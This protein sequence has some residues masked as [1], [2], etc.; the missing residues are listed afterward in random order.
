M[1]RHLV[2][3]LCDDG[4]LQQ[5]ALEPKDSFCSPEKQFLLLS[6]MIDI[7]NRGAEMLKLGMPV[8]EL[9]RLPLLSKARRWKI[10]YGSDEMAGLEQ[11]ARQIIPVFDALRAEYASPTI[12]SGTSLEG[13]E[14]PDETRAESGAKHT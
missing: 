1:R 9:L 12:K 5:S 3:P 13:Y 2:T 7:H 8:Q 4:R 6:L 14:V 10:A 11:E